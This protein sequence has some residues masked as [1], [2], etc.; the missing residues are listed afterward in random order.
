MEKTYKQFRELIG[1]TSLPVLVECWASWCLPCKQ[2]DG[3]LK[4]F[5]QQF[6]D[7]C[8]I[9]KVNVDRNPKMSVD[10]RVQGLPTFLMLYN[11]EVKDR[12]IGS[13]S[14]DAL[15]AMIEDAI[16][17]HGKGGSDSPH[18]DESCTQQEEDRIIEDQLKDLGYL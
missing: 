16:A 5:A 6:G 17:A 4:E 3:I 2:Y 12:K 7:S 11:G 13:Q 8:E 18:K 1:S 9:V 15:R 10:Y 14:R